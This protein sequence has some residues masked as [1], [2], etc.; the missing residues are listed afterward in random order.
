MRSSLS[1]QGRGSPTGALILRMIS[2]GP[3]LVL[4]RARGR[5]QELRGQAAFALLGVDR[6]A[7]IEGRTADF[8]SRP[9]EAEE[10]GRRRDCPR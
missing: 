7:E 9:I 2:L 10:L 4:E 1:L 3:R 8:G 5:A 6:L